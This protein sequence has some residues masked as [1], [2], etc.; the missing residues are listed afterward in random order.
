MRL[1]SHEWR[2]SASALPEG[3]KVFE[4]DWCFVDT[5][6]DYHARLYYFSESDSPSAWHWRVWIDNKLY[7]GNAQ[8]RNDA[9]DEC[10][11][12]LVKHNVILSPLESN[13]FTYE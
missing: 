9:R 6:G 7:R 11:R 8:T 12:L 1:N 2:S 13:Q 5:K 10:E 4:D 3:A